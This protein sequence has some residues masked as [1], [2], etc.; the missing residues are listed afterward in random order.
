MK[1]KTGS[2]YLVLWRRGDKLIGFVWKSKRD[3]DLAVLLG[4]APR[5]MGLIHEAIDGT[6]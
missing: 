3:V 4:E 1:Y 6:Q 5:L 2:G